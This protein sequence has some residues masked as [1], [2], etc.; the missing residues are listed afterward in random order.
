M[1]VKICGITRP[2]DAE[3]GAEL[4]VDAIGINLVPSSTRFVEIDGAR[5]VRSAIPDGVMAVGVFQGHTI[6]Q[7]LKLSES[8]GLDAVQ[9][10]GPYTPDERARVGATVS[11][12]IHAFSLGQTSWHDVSDQ[13]AATEPVDEHDAVVMLDAPSPGGGVPFDWNL[14][15]QLPDDHDVLLAG[16]LHP[17]N[18]AD[19]IEQVQPWGVDV[20]SGVESTP[21]IKDRAMMENF[22]AA[23]KNTPANERSS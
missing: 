20:A 23:A 3:T 8:L 4:G 11:T 19:A 9:L 12:L 1:F 18:V 10:H 14:V 7:I 21:G 6:E 13:M 17:G 22:I 16:G 5:A 2:E 15:G